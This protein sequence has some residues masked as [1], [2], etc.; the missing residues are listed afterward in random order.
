MNGRD[1]GADHDTPGTGGDAA[2]EDAA[3]GGDDPEHAPTTLVVGETIVDAHPDGPGGLAERDTYHR[4]A[5]G[6][7]ANVAV[8]LARLGAPPAFWTRVGDDGFGDF[9][10]DTLAAEGIPTTLVERDPSAPTGLAVVSLDADADREFVLYLDGT[11]STRLQPGRVADERLAAVDWLHVGGVELAHEPARSAVLDLLDRAPPDTTVSFDPNARPQLWTEFDYAESVA[12]VLPAVDV[13][14][15]SPEDL[16]P[17]GYEG[18]PRD[19]ARTLTDATWG[20]ATPDT[21][22]D[23]VGSSLDGTGPHTVAITRGDAGAV[24]HATESAPWGPAT[25]SHEGLAVDPVDTTGAGD[26]FTAGL[27]ASLSGEATTGSTTDAGPRD[28]DTALAA[29]VRF[30]NA[31]AAHSTTARGAMAAL[32]DRDTVERLLRE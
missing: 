27:I 4:R 6:A 31:A 32:P 1:A 14:V 24:A 23:A 25:T 13:L 9:L 17:A 5:G 15:A 10:A 16:A 26:A 22:T 29:A 2:G 30:A 11:A 3:T 20:T 7:P 18:A 12:A 19:L 28:G 8:G 21:E